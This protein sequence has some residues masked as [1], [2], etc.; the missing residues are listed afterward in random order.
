MSQGDKDDSIQPSYVDTPAER[1][2]HPEKIADTVL[3]L[4][5]NGFVA[6]INLVVDGGG[7][8]V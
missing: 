1:I 4:T 2:G 7:L 8:L 3:F 6:G 5:K